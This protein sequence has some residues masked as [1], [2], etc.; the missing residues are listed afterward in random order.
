MSILNINQLQET[1]DKVPRFRDEN[2]RYTWFSAYH[3][4]RICDIKNVSGIHATMQMYNTLKENYTTFHFN[5]HNNAKRKVVF[6]VKQGFSEN[7]TYGGYFLNQYA[8]TFLIERAQF[9]FGVVFQYWKYNACNHHVQPVPVDFALRRTL[10]TSNTSVETLDDS[11]CSTT[12]RD[13]H[14]ITTRRQIEKSFEY[15]MLKLRLIHEK[16]FEYNMFKLQLEHQQ[17][18]MKLKKNE[19]QCIEEH[20]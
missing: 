13:E 11:S 7:E 8:V 3:V 5:K 18:I 4:F 15:H 12:Q 19:E 16:F 17:N 9:P 14:E 10:V 20:T 2:I 1:F 6:L